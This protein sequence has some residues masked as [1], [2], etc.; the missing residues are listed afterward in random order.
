MISYSIPFL[1]LYS[2]PYIR[3][4]CWSEYYFYQYFTLSFLFLLIDA[5]SKVFPIDFISLF[6]IRVIYCHDYIVPNKSSIF[7]C[8]LIH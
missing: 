2:T 7:Y 5:G 3:S 6:R 8:C 1:M 4:Y